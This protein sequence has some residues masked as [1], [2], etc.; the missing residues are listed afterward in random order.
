M[1]KIIFAILL[2]LA[3]NGF[4]FARIGDV[5]ANGGAPNPSPD[6]ISV[7]ISKIAPKNTIIGQAVKGTVRVE[8]VCSG[9][10]SVLAEPMIDFGDGNTESIGDP[11]HC[12]TIAL[13]GLSGEPR[14]VKCDFEFS[15]IYNATGTYSIIPSASWGGG[16]PHIGGGLSTGLPETVTITAAPTPSVAT[17]ADNPLAATTTA[18]LIRSMTNVIFY[19]VSAL[20][21]LLIVVGGFILITSAGNPKQLNQGKKIILFTLVGYA[22]M[23]IAGGIVALIYRILDVN[24]AP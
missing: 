16:P 11:C 12:F 21:V 15:H 14:E 22:I 20:A 17:S 13:F 10:S 23:L 24:I 18:G 9:N 1:R 19:I 5:C 3:I 4:F 6:E 2:A 7:Y 8:V